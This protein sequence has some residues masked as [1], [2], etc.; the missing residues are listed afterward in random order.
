VAR[1]SSWTASS[2]AAQF[3]DEAK[4]T[5]HFETAGRLEKFFLPRMKIG[6][7]VIEEPLRHN[8]MVRARRQS[9]VGV[10]LRPGSEEQDKAS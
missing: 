10:L 6:A 4:M 5:A 2:Y 8:G 9:A 1:Q 7:L 3:A